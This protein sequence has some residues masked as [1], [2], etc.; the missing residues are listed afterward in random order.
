MPRRSRGE[1]FDDATI[2]ESPLESYLDLEAMDGQVRL[3][4]SATLRMWRHSY[5]EAN[6]RTEDCCPRSSER[7]NRWNLG[8]RALVG[9]RVR[10]SS[11]PWIKYVA[12]L[13]LVCG[14]IIRTS[15]PSTVYSSVR[16]IPPNQ[17]YCL[18]AALSLRYGWI[19]SASGKKATES[20]AQR[21]V[22]LG[23]N[24]T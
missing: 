18:N 21:M 4:Y 1:I 19:G 7:S 15:K 20:F 2:H 6:D 13:V 8:H 23:T 16:A 22:S 24:T 12:S 10:K 5:A 9:I 11:C 17:H 14:V 3:I